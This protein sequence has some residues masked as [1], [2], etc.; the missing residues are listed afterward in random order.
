MPRIAWEGYLLRTAKPNDVDFPTGQFLLRWRSA[1]FRILR[2]VCVT[3]NDLQKFLCEEHDPDP[4][5][6]RSAQ[7]SLTE[8]G[9]AWFV[10]LAASHE[11]RVDKLFSK[12]AESNLG[13]V[14][15]LLRQVEETGSSEEIT[16]KDQNGRKTWH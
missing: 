6:R 7:A 1:W 15:V 16:D 13:Q 12:L 10:K 8:Q 4:M 14:K 2:F 9:K 5:D 11:M 3:E